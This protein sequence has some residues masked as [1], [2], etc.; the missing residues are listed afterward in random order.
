MSSEFTWANE[1][2]V[3]VLLLTLI[4]IAYVGWFRLAL[5]GRLGNPLDWKSA[6]FPIPK[7]SAGRAASAAAV[8]SVLQDVLSREEI[9][10]YGFS[11]RNG[12]VDRQHQRLFGHA[13][14][15]RLAM[16]SGQSADKLNEIIDGFVRDMVQHFQ[17][18]ETTLAAAGDPKIGQHTTEHR[19]LAEGVQAAVVRFRAGVEGINELFRFIARDVLAK[20]AMDEERGLL[21]PA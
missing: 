10:S 9:A 3:F 18:E 7:L 16:L 13:H 2:Y 17:D 19:E 20:H 5:T 21:L 4:G 1:L 12:L 15:L 14:D 11:W 8:S 6:D